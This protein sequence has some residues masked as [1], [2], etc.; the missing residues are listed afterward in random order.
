MHVYYHNF[1]TKHLDHPPAP[2][3]HRPWMFCF[4]FF[5]VAL[6][7][8]QIFWILLIVL[9]Y[10]ILSVNM[11]LH[12]ISMLCLKILCFCVFYSIFYVLFL[13]FFSFV[14]LISNLFLKFTFLNHFSLTLTSQSNPLSLRSMKTMPLFRALFITHKDNFLSKCQ[15]V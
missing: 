5:C 4:F 13:N 14:F 2:H 8:K 1:P 11:Y 6:T 3:W 10:S 7:L 12:F 9:W 15:L